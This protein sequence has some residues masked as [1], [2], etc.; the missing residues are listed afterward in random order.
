MW[1]VMVLYFPRLHCAS[2]DGAAVR[3]LAQLF[4]SMFFHAV[5]NR[6]S[7]HDHEECSTDDC[8]MSST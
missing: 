3:L 8:V 7:R 6:Y 1:I 2:V 4:L 5:R